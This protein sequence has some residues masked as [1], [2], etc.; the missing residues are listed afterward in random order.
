MTAPIRQLQALVGRS[1]ANPHLPVTHSD[2]AT[3]ATS[4]PAR[5][6]ETATTAGWTGRATAAPLEAAPGTVPLRA[7]S[8]STASP[9]PRRARQ[10]NS[11]PP[12]GSLQSTFFFAPPNV[13]RFSC[14]RLWRDGC[15]RN[16]RDGGDPSAASACWAKLGQS[17]LARHSLRRGDDGRLTLR[18]TWRNSTDGRTD[19]PR[20][21]RA[22]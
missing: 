5:P 19:R 6:G 7:A 2:A 21:C 12:A 15:L 3:T 8:G 10:E 16:H 11:K 4:S 13:L 17:A 22:F 18:P 9:P 14:G 1:A 20:N